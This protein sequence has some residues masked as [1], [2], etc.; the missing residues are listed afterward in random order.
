MNGAR[1]EGG[2]APNQ[3]LQVY[4]QRLDA[5]QGSWGEKM[6][7]LKK[8]KKENAKGNYAPAGGQQQSDRRALGRQ[9]IQMLEYTQ[10]VDAMGVELSA[11]SCWTRSAAMWDCFV[12]RRL[13]RFGIERTVSISVA[14]WYIL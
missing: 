7:P 9:A 2:V 11:L 3:V 12:V 6:A 8:E 10:H 4:R 13:F 14:V 5:I 1:N